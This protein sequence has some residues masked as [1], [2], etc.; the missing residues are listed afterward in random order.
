MTQSALDL[1]F[2]RPDAMHHDALAKAIGKDRTTLYRYRRGE[3]PLTAETIQAICEATG[4]VLTPADF[5]PGV[6]GDGG[7]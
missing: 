1:Y 3:I 2:H 5:F 7:E 6:Y 4:L